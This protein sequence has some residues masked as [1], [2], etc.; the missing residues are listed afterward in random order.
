MINNSYNM[1]NIFPSSV[2]SQCPVHHIPSHPFTPG[3]PVLPSSLS[4][5]YP[6]PN[7]PPHHSNIFNAPRSNGNACSRTAPS[8]FSSATNLNRQGGVNEPEYA[9]NNRADTLHVHAQSVCTCPSIRRIVRLAILCRE[10]DSVASVAIG[11]FIT[12]C[13]DYVQLSYD[14]EHYILH[15]HP[16]RAN[17]ATHINEMTNE[18]NKIFQ[19]TKMIRNEP[20]VISADY[21]EYLNQTM[22]Q[23]YSGVCGEPKACAVHVVCAPMHCTDHANVPRNPRIASAPLLSNS[24]PCARN[25]ESIKTERSETAQPSQSDKSMEEVKFACDHCGKRYKHLCNLKSHQRIHTDEAL[26]CAHCNKRFGRKANLAEHLRIHTG[27]APYQCKFCLRKFKH[28]HSWRD[29]LRIHTGEQPYQCKVCGR[30][31]KVGHNLKV[32]ARIH[33]GEKPYKCPHC[34]KLFRQKSGLN[35][36][37]KRAHK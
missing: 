34:N 26:I 33:T 13:T 8:T 36:H 30:R 27:E 11:Q 6:P 2:N 7:I 12:N 19:F 9:A 21:I 16:S 10:Y 4:M 17:D 1:I 31:F 37:I 18:Y 22:T 29:H 20:A 24:P 5:A 25:P 15:L 14:Y 35:S 23:I 32:H 28:H 3:I